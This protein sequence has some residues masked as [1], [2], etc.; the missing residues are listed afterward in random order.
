MSF[1]SGERPGSP[2]DVYD[3]SGRRWVSVVYGEVRKTFV[4]SGVVSGVR[5]DVSVARGV[6]LGA[7]GVVSV[8]AGGVSVARGGVSVVRGGVSVVRGVISVAR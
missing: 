7:R 8:V 5:E 4:S 2:E 3:S 1:V 6:I